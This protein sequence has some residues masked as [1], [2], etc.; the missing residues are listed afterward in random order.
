MIK[1]CF[2]SIAFPMNKEV[3]N[4]LRAEM[5]RIAEMDKHLEFWF[6]GCHDS[7]PQ[8][9]VQFIQELRDVLSSSQIDIVAVSDPIHNEKWNIADYDEVKNGFPKGAVTRVEEAPRIE[10]KSEQYE[11]RFVEHSRKVSRWYMEQCDII[12]AYHYDNI[13]HSVNT[14]IKRLKKRGKPEIISIYDPDFYQSIDAYIASMEDR[15]GL[16]LQRLRDGDTYKTLADELGITVNR[17]QQIASRATRKV[18]HFI[19]YG[20]T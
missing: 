12:L 18:M 3:I 7:F 11:N 15:D 10:G 2:L 19:R 20:Q 8:K 5:I 16:I 4:R 1:V 17:V 6:F 9:A 14:E 13:P